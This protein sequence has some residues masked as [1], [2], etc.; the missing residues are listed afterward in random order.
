M[1]LREKKRATCA[2]L[3]FNYTLF[4]NQLRMFGCFSFNNSSRHN[5]ILFFLG[6]Q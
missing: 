4:I 2:I 5:I 6:F 3:N 1:P